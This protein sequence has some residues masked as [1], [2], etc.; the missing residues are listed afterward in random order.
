M[1]APG[2]QQAG[3]GGQPRPTLTVFDAVAMIV[4]IVI[5]VGIFKAPAIVAGNV[6]GETA[7]IALWII[8]GLVSL[9]GALCYAELGS[10]HP[11]AG[12]EY[13]FL[14]KAYGDWL[15][16]LF[17]WARMTV[18]QTGAIAAIAFVFGDYAS[19]LLP[20]GSKS[21]AIYAGLAVIAITAL[22]VAGTSQSKWVQNVLT[23][24]LALAVLVIVVSGL[25][26]SGA[27]APAPAPA[28]A[29]GK[30]WFSGLAL[31]FVLLTYGGW[32]EAAYLTAEMRD[33]RRNIV[34]ALVIGIVVITVL[35]LLLNLAYLKA[36][37]LAGMQSSKAIA[38][39]LMR[40]TWGEGGAWLLGIV[41]VS[42]ALSTLNA[43]VFTGAR[44]NYALGRDFV[45]F[46]ALGRW[47][48]KSSAPVNAL[49]V[50]G[51]I[52]L[53][54]VGLASFTPDGFQTM[55]AYTAP[56]FWLFFLLTGISLFLLRRQPPANAD[57]FRV[58]LYPLT[59]ILFAAAC[60][61]ML[62]SSFNYAMS[63]DP[64]SIGAMVGIAMLASGIPV[65]MWAKRRAAA[66][67]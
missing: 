25:T 11:N 56:A 47:N 13:Y 9:V 6:S 46:R 27:T 18:I 52:S 4:G 61:W 42:A 14:S 19:A 54:L 2:Q 35:Y 65:L 10:S 53:A 49:L 67:R 45:I 66:D 7:F 24:A 48:E 20:L 28:P 26:A 31:I 12:G 30:A 17:A 15:G 36:L 23:T 38:S 41:V 16:F 21:S 1:T 37:G 33:T 63:L 62:Y 55:V 57:P 60:A 34:R 22:N 40:V 29:E 58:P 44:T 50:Q 64:G 8:G 51:A 5:G 43:T 59:P 32:N 39:D 3:G